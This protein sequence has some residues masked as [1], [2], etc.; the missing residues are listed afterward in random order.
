MLAIE[1]QWKP[2]PNANP[3]PNAK[4]NIDPLLVGGECMPSHYPHFALNLHL[5]LLGCCSIILFPKWETACI[6]P[7]DII[8]SRV[9]I[10]QGEADGSTC[11]HTKLNFSYILSPDM[12]PT[13]F[14]GSSSPQIPYSNILIMWEIVTNVTTHC[15]CVCSVH[16][17]TLEYG[18]MLSKH[19]YNLVSNHHAPVMWESST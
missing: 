1:E 12:S 13:C 19:Q 5:P 18:R 3:D 2:N 7:C 10:L 14:C 9:K 4:L 15:K 16:W 6:T 8:T 17:E 11:T